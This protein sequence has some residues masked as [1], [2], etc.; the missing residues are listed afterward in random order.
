[1]SAYPMNFVVFVKLLERDCAEK[2]TI[3]HSARMLFSRN[4]DTHDRATASRYART[5]GLTR[6]RDG[7]PPAVPRYT[8]CALRRRFATRFSTH[9]CAATMLA[10]SNSSSSRLSVICRGIRPST[11][12]GSRIAYKRSLLSDRPRLLASSTL[13][14]IAGLE[15]PP[16]SHKAKCQ[17]GQS[18]AE[19]DR[20][21]HVGNAVKTPAESADQVHHRVK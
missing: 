21:R 16:H 7:L 11:S 12:S 17:E 6:G 5:Q 10:W 19:T 1:M 15:N 3:W 4:R 18:H 2:V 13:K 14:T 9:S 8:P 20:H